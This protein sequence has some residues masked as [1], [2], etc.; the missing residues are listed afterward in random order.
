MFPRLDDAPLWGTAFFRGP[1]LRLPLTLSN[2]T[3]MLDVGTALACDGSGGH[4]R[5]LGVD[6]RECQ[7]GRGEPADMI[8]P[9][10]SV[11]AVGAAFDHG[12]QITAV[13][14]VQRAARDGQSRFHIG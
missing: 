5:T 7:F 14:N 3:D 10:G 9:D 12:E 11:P 2:L 13:I 4:V 6:H 8:P 1:L